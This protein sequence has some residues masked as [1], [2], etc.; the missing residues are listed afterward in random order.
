MKAFAASAFLLLSANVAQTALDC[1]AALS[2]CSRV[3]IEIKILLHEFMQASIQSKQVL[4]G[5]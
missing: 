3:C 1:S 5:Q 4:L 2:T